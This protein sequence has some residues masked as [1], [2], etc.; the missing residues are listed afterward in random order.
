[1]STLEPVACMPNDPSI[2][3]Q[4]HESTEIRGRMLRQGARW[5]CRNSKD[6]DL[7][8]HLLGAVAVAVAASDQYGVPGLRE[9]KRRLAAD[10]AGR[11]GH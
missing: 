7:P 2:A 3:L 9:A 5:I 4:R 10:A 1:M 11:P 8:T 6:G